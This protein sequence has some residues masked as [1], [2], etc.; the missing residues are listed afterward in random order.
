MKSGVL[1][2]VTMKSVP[3]FH[4]TETVRFFGTSVNFC[5]AVP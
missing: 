2:D 5:Q 3:V 1:T 4:T